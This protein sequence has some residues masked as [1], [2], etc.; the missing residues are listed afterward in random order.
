MARDEEW[1]SSNNDQIL[2]LVL[3]HQVTLPVWYSSSWPNFIAISSSVGLSVS[4]S[5]LSNVCKVA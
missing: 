1:G 2:G 3:C 5:N 4:K